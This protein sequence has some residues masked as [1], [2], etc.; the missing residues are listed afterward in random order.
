MT[1]KIALVTGSAR[2]I[3]RAIALDLA[4]QGAD[5]VVNYRSRPDAAE[6]VAD[7]IRGMGRRALVLGADVADDGQ[8]SLSTMRHS[9][10][11]GGFKL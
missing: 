9:T 5:I 3:G 10:G 11:G 7:K 6:E 2:G 4:N 1:S 8:V